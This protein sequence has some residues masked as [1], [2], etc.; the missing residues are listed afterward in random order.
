MTDANVNYE[1]LPADMRKDETDINLRLL[2]RPA[3]GRTVGR[4]RPFLD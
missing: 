4:V 2:F 1:K 3:V